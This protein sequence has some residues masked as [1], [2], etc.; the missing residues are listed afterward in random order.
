MTT[1]TAPTPEPAPAPRRSG[2]RGVFWPLALIA[3]G[4]VFLLANYGLIE[5]VS[6]VTLL[7]LW[8]VLLILIG[9][10]IAFARRWPIAT[11]VAEVA[12]IGLALLLAATQPSVLTLAPFQFGG[13]NACREPSGQVSASRGNADSLD[14]RVRGGAAR[15]RVTGGASGLLE[16]TWDPGLCLSDRRNGSRAE[17]ELTQ[18]GARP[19]RSSDEVSVRVATDVPLALRFDAGAGDFFVDLHDVRTSEAR[20]NVGASSMT[21]VLPHPS[22]DVGVRIDGGAANVNIE[23]PSDV[24]ARITVSGGLVS[25]NTANSRTTK[26]GNVIQTAGYGAAKDRVT[27]TVNGGASSVNVR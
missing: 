10:D 7:A 3:V 17:L 8:P 19:G 23:I 26:D 18:G 2:R 22:G 20:F 16:A 12:I 13:S 5:P 11:L 15:Y 4:L 1:E 21:L 27:V 6:F 9:I 14:L 25:S 24:E